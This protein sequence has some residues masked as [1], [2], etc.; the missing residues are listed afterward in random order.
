MTVMYRVI[1]CDQHQERL[2][3]FQQR[4]KR[5]GL[6]QIAR[7]PCVNGK[8]FTR[9]ILCRM[10]KQGTVAPRAELTPIEVAIC[11]SH[12]KCWQAFLRSKAQHLV[13]F[14][15][16]T[17]LKRNF[18]RLLPALLAQPFDVLW[19]YN[20]NWESTRSKR[21][22]MG[23]VQGLT[24]YRETVPY[25]AGAV[26]Y[27]L[28]RDF[29][30]ELL[31]QQ[32]PLRHPVDYFMGR[33]QLRKRLHLSLDT[34]P[35][36][37]GSSTCYTISPVLWT[38]CPYEGS[39]AHSTQDYAAQTIKDKRCPPR[40]GGSTYYIGNSDDPCQECHCPLTCPGE[41]YD[42]SAE[43]IQAWSK[44]ELEKATA[45]AESNLTIPTEVDEIKQ[46]YIRLIRQAQ[47][48]N[49]KKDIVKAAMSAL[50]LDPLHRKID[51]INNMNEQDNL[52]AMIQK[53]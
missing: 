10:V 13:V 37:R 36:K 45:E 50:V 9:P 17:K 3:Q 21:R 30:Q 4:A 33:V 18:S 26:A 1:N 43:C 32:L 38:N 46:T 7:Q 51:K 47:T 53:M 34:V 29:A 42:T 48:I 8:A 14:E 28:R 35:D 23:S 11:L 22:R 20:G 52:I 39:A 15:D 2:R 44:F 12:R 16:D 24:L 25:T 40:G 41:G 19:M 31:R 49:D 5:A 6:P 27:C